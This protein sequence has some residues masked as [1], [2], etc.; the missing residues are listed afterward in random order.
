M[1]LSL[2]NATFVG[3]DEVNVYLESFYVKG[4]NIRFVQVPDDVD[5]LET[6]KGWVNCHI[7]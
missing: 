3:T 6:I 5:M 7:C 4:K 1:N 2:R